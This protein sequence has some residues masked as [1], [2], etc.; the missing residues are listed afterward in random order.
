MRSHV[1]KLNL[2]WLLPPT[3]WTASFIYNI[4]LIAITKKKSQE[5]DER[6]FYGV[7]HNINCQITSSELNNIC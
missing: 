3:S 7:I 6:L 5:E 2:F 4:E 1:R